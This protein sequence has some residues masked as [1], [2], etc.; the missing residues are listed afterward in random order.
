MTVKIRSSAQA[1][2]LTSSIWQCYTPRPLVTWKFIKEN[3]GGNSVRLSHTIT[4]YT[5]NSPHETINTVNS[6]GYYVKKK[7]YVQWIPKKGPLKPPQP[8]R[9]TRLPEIRPFKPVLFRKVLRSPTLPHQF[10]LIRNP[11][12]RALVESRWMVS[13]QKRFNELVAKRAMIVKTATENYNVRRA[14]IVAKRRKLLAKEQLRWDKYYK[15][16]DKYHLLL[17]FQKEGVLRYRRVLGKIK[18]RNGY[19]RTRYI[20]FGVSGYHTNAYLTVAPHY[21]SGTYGQYV[22]SY[23]TTLYESVPFLTVVGTLPA[24]T[25][26]VVSATESRAI[27]KLYNNLNDQKLHVGNIVAE[28]A[29]TYSLVKD[30]CM[31]ILAFKRNPMSFIKYFTDRGIQKRASNDTLAF[32]FGVKPLIQDVYN[33]TEAL[34]NAAAAIVA[35]KIEIRASSRGTDSSSFVTYES[36]VNYKR[37]W[38]I[39]EEVLVHYSLSYKVVNGTSAALS[40][41]GLQNPAEIA[42]EMMPWSFVIDWILPV[43]NYIRSFSSDAGLVFES[44]TKTIV[45]RRTYVLKRSRDVVP[46]G[47]AP[48][49]KVEQQGSYFL[50]TKVRTVISTAPTPRLPAFKNPLSLYHI[51]ELLAL[52]T[53]RRT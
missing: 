11:D 35:D 44:G 46:G 9:I 53:Q 47:G 40:Q 26:N 36:P 21:N 29:Q 52:I 1:G 3:P 12:K 14:G 33:A 50:E 49:F 31:R 13:A 30:L 28:R 27:R 23:S 16:L 18:S 10:S 38:E 25:S 32:L 34:K 2:K 51:I 19:S 20:D 37:E 45:T 22:N 17:S 6:T 15:A 7:V 5:R 39:Q 24:S 42:W 43:G 8:P 41:L 4:N 48:W